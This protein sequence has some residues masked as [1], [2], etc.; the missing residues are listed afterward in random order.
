MD[1]AQNRRLAS[2]AAIVMTSVIISRITGYVREMLIP[3]KFGIGAIGDAY[4]I[5]FL[6]PDLMFSLLIGGALSAALVPVLSGY[7]ER[8]EEKEGWRSISTFFCITFVLMM[9]FCTL[10]IIFAPQLLRIVAAGYGRTMPEKVDLTVGLTRVLFSSVSFLMLAGLC[11][12]VLNSYRRF[13]AAAWGPSIYNILCAASIFFLSNNRIEDNYGVQ[14]VVYGVAFSSFAYFIFQFSFAFKNFRHNFRF[15]IELKHPGFQRLF[16]LAIPSLISSSVLQIN[17]IINQS[18]TTMFNDPG[19]V[20][21]LRTADRT[22]QMPLGIIAQAMGVALLPTLSARLAV[23]DVKSYKDTLTS[24]LKSVL[25]LSVPSAIGI[26]VLN[27]LIIGTL[28]K[29]SELVS[30]RG[31]ALTANILFFFSIAL[32]SQSMATILNRGFFAAND[33]RT[34]LFVSMG[35]ILINILL[36]VLFFNFTNLGVVG[37]ALAY[38]IS[39]L[40]NA[41]LLMYLLNR[42]MKGINLKSLGRFCL[43]LILPTAAMAAVLL[44]LSYLIPAE[45]VNG[46]LS[47]GL[48]IRQVSILCAEVIIGICIYF[49]LSYAMKIEEARFIASVLFGRVRRLLGKFSNNLQ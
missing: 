32:I 49:S 23:G 11:N 30:D 41:F 2:A 37:M 5:A 1:S 27:Q 34:T 25:M 33:T 16:K 20:T 18:L 45:L 22:W 24:G 14:K 7:L 13:A 4:N 12:G 10:G 43:R 39:S 36:S 8:N 47:I 28:F 3:A 21:A 44:L 17:I 6:V 31:V 42:K 35:T 9:V 19:A 15:G 48:K 46:D 29:T 38:T 40:I 26:L